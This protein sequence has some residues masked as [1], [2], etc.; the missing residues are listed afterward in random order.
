MEREV[1]SWSIFLP[2]STVVHVCLH[3]FRR[4]ETADLFIKPHRMSARESSNWSCVWPVC[5]CLFPERWRN[6]TKALLGLLGG[7]Y[8]QSTDCDISSRLAFSPLAVWCLSFICSLLC[9][10][11]TD[12]EDDYRRAASAWCSRI[13]PCSFVS[14]VQ[15]WLL[16]VHTWKYGVSKVSASQFLS[17]R[18]LSAL[19]LWEKLLPCWRRPRLHGLYS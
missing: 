17:P 2:Q 9:C 1:P 12:G 3:V 11:C 19:R 6:E 10:R 18:R 16:Q 15:G 14:S 8:Q 4:W 7:F 5:T 13:C